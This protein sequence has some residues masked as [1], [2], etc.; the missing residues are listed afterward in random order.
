M[1]SNKRE[2]LTQELIKLDKD[3]ENCDQ[4]R[5]LKVFCQ[6]IEFKNFLGLSSIVAKLTKGYLDNQLKPLLE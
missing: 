5:I 4:A 2:T 6:V 1:D 3:L